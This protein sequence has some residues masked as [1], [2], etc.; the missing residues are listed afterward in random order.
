MES[1]FFNLKYGETS[2]EINLS[3]VNFLGELKAKSMPKVDSIKNLVLE[4]FKNPTTGTSIYQ[5]S[6]PQ[7]KV[8]I[9]CSD[10]TRKTKI[11]LILPLLLDELNKIGVP[12]ENIFVVFATGTH[13]LHTKEEQIKIL[14]QNTA[15]RIK[16]YDHNCKDEANLKFI[17]KTSRGTPISVNSQVLQANK[18]ILTGAITYHYFVGFSGGPKAVLPGISSFET[19]QTNHRLV[20]NSNGGGTNPFAKTGNL[21]D[22]PV[23]EDMLEAMA[24]L[25]PG[26]LINTVIDAEG[27]LA[28]IF[29]GHPKTAHRKGT[30]FINS[31]CKIKINEKADLVVVSAG[32]VPKDLNFVQ[33]HK[34]IENASYALKGGGTMMVFAQMKEAFPSSVYTEW[35]EH[36]SPEAI[37][38]ALFEHFT[39]PGHTVYSSLRKAKRFK[40]ILFSSF[41]KTQV[42]KMGMIP[43][44]SAEEAVNLAF[45]NLPDNSSCY[46]MPEGYNTF[47]VVQ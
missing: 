38:E 40:I 23:Y 20:L 24:L 28:G 31:F 10:K 36:P 19:I 16:F 27:N 13:G 33:A 17:G 43:A 22:N 32:G 29:C 6:R 39:I 45:K 44:H 5:I 25:N 1:K 47:P 35:F 14:G 21:K 4:T 2:H 7:D 46:V 3:K 11:D 18:I 42:E 9:V 26:F 37:E 12:D 15:T 30:E 34:A 8:C 41:S